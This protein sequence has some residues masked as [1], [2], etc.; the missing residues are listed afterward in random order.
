MTRVGQDQFLKGATLP[1][2]LFQNCARLP[3]HRLWRE[4]LGTWPTW[5]RTQL[6]EK[7][8]IDR[9]YLSGIE[10]GVRKRGVFGLANF[11]EI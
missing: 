5:N 8:D 9:T 1:A 4:Y 2:V 7:A 6:A 3:N 11:L 10:R